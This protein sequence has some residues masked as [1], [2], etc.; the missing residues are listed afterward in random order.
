MI[1]RKEVSFVTEYNKMFREAFDRIQPAADDKS[2]IESVTE[3]KRNMKKDE[4]E[5]REL[6]EITVPKVEYKPRKAPWIAAIAGFTAAAAGLGFF[7]GTGFGRNSGGVPLSGGGNS[8]NAEQSG[9]DELSE[10]YEKTY[11]VKADN[12]Y[13]QTDGYTVH[14]FGYRFDSITMDLYYEVLDEDGN[15]T[16]YFI[17]CLTDADATPFS[18][19]EMELRDGKMAYH[20][21]LVLFQPQ[22]TFSVCFAGQDRQLTAVPHPD[23]D[24]L[25]INCAEELGTDDNLMLYVSPYEAV[26][27]CDEDGNDKGTTFDIVTA[28]NGTISFGKYSNAVSDIKYKGVYG[29][30]VKGKSFT[31]VPLTDEIGVANVAKVLVDGKTV[32]ESPT[33]YDTEHA[34]YTAVVMD[35][36]D[37]PA[38]GLYP[39]TYTNDNMSIE[40]VGYSYDYQ[41]MEISVK[42]SEGYEFDNEHSLYL[43]YADNTDLCGDVEILPDNTLKITTNIFVPPYERWDFRLHYAADRLSLSDETVLASFE[44]RGAGLMTTNAD[45]TT[46]TYD[47]DDPTV[48]SEEWHDIAAVGS[49]DNYIYDFSDISIRVLEWEFD[50]RIFKCDFEILSG[51]DPEN[52]TQYFS[53][54]YKTPKGNLM[55]GCMDN[56]NGTYTMFTLLDD[57][58]EGETETLVIRYVNTGGEGGE[59][60]VE[61]GPE[62][63]VTG[64][65][66]SVLKDRIGVDLTEFG[67]AGAKLE[68]ATLSPFGLQLDITSTTDISD[69]SFSDKLDIELT[70]LAGNKLDKTA[71][72]YDTAAVKDEST[73]KYNIKILCE[74]KAVGYDLMNTKE[75]SISGFKFKKAEMMPLKYWDGLLTE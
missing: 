4:Y 6:H 43:T 27:M 2:F 51:Y 23:I 5:R 29:G 16:D 61:D 75:I 52:H 66:S 49:F 32:Y 70:D 31:L 46:V 42:P 30:S 58:P 7:A 37:L 28:Y 17:E 69:G 24:V 38:T 33:A 64:S 12:I 60:T 62:F 11:F 9:T 14:V 18:V 21:T 1:S 15:N 35:I 39:G 22:E 73:E 74:P 20:A 10:L 56:E 40:V 48:S 55:H 53:A 13:Y 72:A 25:K 47:S 36:P 44:V 50:G 63:T 65:S 3:R 41:T 68:W 57:L 26:A 67:I 54:E 19:A 71:F 45:V 34:E 8:A 59:H